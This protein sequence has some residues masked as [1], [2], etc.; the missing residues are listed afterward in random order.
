M[1]VYGILKQ[2]ASW[3]K[4][5]SRLWITKLKIF[6]LHECIFVVLR[7]YCYLGVLF[8]FFEGRIIYMFTTILFVSYLPLVTT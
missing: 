8:Y 6:F 4:P 1:K 3:Y 2:N 5:H 7:H